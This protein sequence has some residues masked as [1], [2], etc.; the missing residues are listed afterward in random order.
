MRAGTAHGK[1]LAMDSGV[2]LTSHYPSLCFLSGATERS[3]KSLC[4]FPLLSADVLSSAWEAHSECTA[5]PVASC[6][7]AEV[8][9][10]LPPI[11]PPQISVVVHVY[12]NK[13]HGIREKGPRRFSPSPRMAAVWHRVPMCRT[14]TVAQTTQD[15]GDLR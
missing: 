9:G 5:F 3:A 10:Q 11:M 13:F 15:H 6:Q 8:H 14:F 12:R 7:S 4:L 1:D 2:Y